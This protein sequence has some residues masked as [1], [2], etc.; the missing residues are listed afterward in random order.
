MPEGKGFDIDK[1]YSYI[2]SQYDPSTGLVRENE[3][4]NRYWLWTDNLLASHVLKDRDLALSAK[5]GN[6]VK[7]YST[8]YQLQFR[9]PIAS[10]FNKPAYF[11]PV[12]DTNITGNVWASIASSEGQDLECSDYADIAFLKSIHHY[13]AK[14]YREARDC[15]EHGR[16]M[17]DGY[18]F[19]DKAF[20]TD[21]NRYT[22]Y[23]LALWKIA[24]DTTGYGKEGEGSIAL[25]ILAL[26]QDP[27]TGGVYTHYRE[28]MSI[29][30][31]TNVETT[32]LAIMA[33]NSNS[34]PS[35]Q[36]KEDDGGRW[37]IEYYI[38]IGMIIAAAI[39]IVLRR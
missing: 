19:K 9:H 21:G 10:L 25:R 22:T 30:S 12:T 36:V 23:K 1:A 3:H 28:D 13:N 24:S 11:K 39:A 16:S 38:I 18:G 34:R 4:I 27:N 29:D 7:E 35:D 2:I 32:A 5:I 37:P 15:Y 8:A 31:M 33:Y 26:M 6:K 17:F 20:H 14:Q